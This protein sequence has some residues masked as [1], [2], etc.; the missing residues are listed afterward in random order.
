MAADRSDFDAGQG[1]MRQHLLP[2]VPQDGGEEHE[3]QEATIRSME[4]VIGSST[5]IRVYCEIYNR[6]AKQKIEFG[7]HTLEYNIGCG[8]PDIKKTILMCSLKESA[9]AGLIL[10]QMFI[11]WRWVYPLLTGEV[12]NWP[13]EVPYQWTMFTLFAEFLLP[14]LIVSTPVVML[15]CFSFFPNT[16]EEDEEDFKACVKG[17]FEALFGLYVYLHR[18]ITAMFPL[19]LLYIGGAYALAAETKHTPEPQGST[20]VLPYVLLCCWDTFCAH[21]LKSWLAFSENSC[22]YLVLFKV[23]QRKRLEQGLMH[24]GSLCFSLL[25]TAWVL[26]GV[27]A[28]YK[29]KAFYTVI[30][31][32]DV[33]PAQ[34]ILS[35]LF[36]A[37]AEVGVGPLLLLQKYLIDVVTLKYPCCCDVLRFFCC[38]KKEALL[39][40]GDSDDE[41]SDEK[42]SPPPYKREGQGDLFLDRSD[43][44]DDAASKQEGYSSSAYRREAQGDCFLGEGEGSSVPVIGTL[45]QPAG[46]PG[47]RRYAGWAPTQV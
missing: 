24:N 47:E 37:G 23:D 20:Y 25:K 3:D 4:L 45:N 28:L 39:D 32:S 11:L 46:V 8:R 44:E 19:L 29:G 10:A 15:R 26:N 22:S 13:D 40:L 41:A 38:Q 17:F 16:T 5:V 14:L 43:D 42:Y 35:C 12:S 21:F 7:G 18:A 30:D 31:T 2:P 33:S 6:C 1:T 27:I 36:M 9:V 34:R